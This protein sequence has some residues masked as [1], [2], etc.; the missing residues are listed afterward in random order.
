MEYI[1]IKEYVKWLHSSCEEISELLVSWLKIGPSKIATIDI[2][3][4]DPKIEQ[5]ISNLKSMLNTVDEKHF[6]WAR[7]K[8]NPFEE[9]GRSI[10]IN[11]SA[12]KIAN[13]DAILDFMFTEPRD[14]NSDLMLKNET[15]C[16]ADCCAGPGGFSQYILWRKKMHAKGFGFT[17]RNQNDFEFN[18][19]LDG[20]T[21]SYN[22]YYGI[23]GDGN[24]FDPENITS[25]KKYVLSKT[26]GSGVHFMMADGGFHVGKE[27]SQ[28]IAF[29]Q[30]YIC[31]CLTGLQLVR[32]N[33]SLVVKFFDVVNKYSVGLLYLMYK[34]F[35]HL[36]II[37]PNTS[38]PANS[39][40]YVVFK[41]KR[42]NTDAIQN[43][44]FDVVKK[45]WY[46]S[47]DVVL[48]LVPNEMLIR[49]PNFVNYIIESNN[50]IGRNQV[51]ALT[52]IIN[53]IKTGRKQAV[54]YDNIKLCCLRAWKLPIQQLQTVIFNLQVVH[55]ICRNICL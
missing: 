3:F 53:L 39:E 21:N 24:I 37:K 16:F 13:L 52:K 6:L 30:L 22:A 51:N 31:Q 33:G 8:C 44:L 46:N 2:L 19:F 28:E 7:S 41:H 15:L 35:K 5:E 27:N 32:E 49:D 36:V 29:K 55:P 4:C 26:Y 23:K 9:I 54:D 47:A 20:S 17:L 50:D 12:V 14:E 25:L 34:C 10:F 45:M 43:Y 40:R 48:E 18:Q 11:R 42:A 38:R 1:T